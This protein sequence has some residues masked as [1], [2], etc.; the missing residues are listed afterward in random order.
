MWPR[1][2]RFV[3]LG[4]VIGVALVATRLPSI[5][6]GS[7]VRPARTPLYAATPPGCVDQNFLGDRV[8]LRG[9]HCAALTRRQGTVIY[10]H[11]VA[12][13]RASAA[14]VIRRFTT[15]GLDFIAYDSRGH[16]MSDGESCTYGYFERFD[17]QRVIDNLTPG[18][19]ILIGTSMGAAVALLAAVGHP[20]V[21]GLVAAEVFSDLGAIARERAPRVVPE[22]VLRRVLRVAEQRAQ[23]KIEEVSPIQAAAALHIPVLV[24]HGAEDRDTPP[25][26]ARRVFAAL[27]GR[28]RLVLVAG[29]QHNQA[30]NGSKIWTDVE[31]WVLNV[32]RSVAG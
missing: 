11:G 20:R 10:L 13:N 22:L 32:L 23:F 21:A 15:K 3:R 9:W 6:A 5:A 19:V 26:H 12:D 30:L 14:G 16:G 29:A 31:G 24:I 28:K 27:A 17:L 25:D 18:P 7:F 8:T 2:S 1:P 4:A